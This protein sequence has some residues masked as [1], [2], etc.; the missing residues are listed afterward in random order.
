MNRSLGFLPL[1]LLLFGL[2]GC[3]AS[4]EGR[5]DPSREEPGMMTS[6]TITVSIARPPRD[7]SD[8]VRNPENLTRW[9]TFITAVRQVGDEWAMETAE[10]TMTIRFVDKNN[11]GVLDHRVRL[12]SGTEVLNPMRV[13]SNGQGSE[14]LFTLFRLPEMTGDQFAKDAAT[15]ETDLATL[16]RVLEDP[17][18]PRS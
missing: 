2:V 10:G 13:I 7:V 1:T 6:R 16:K 3:G 14:V 18:R 8:F 4:S 5:V 11:L 9:L 17:A 15:V 12:P